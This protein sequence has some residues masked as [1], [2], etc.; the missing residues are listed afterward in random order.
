MAEAV[1]D[2]WVRTTVDGQSDGGRTLAAGQVIDVSA[3][4]SISLRAGDG[5][6]I[7]V[8]LNRGQKQPLGRSGQPVT[9]EFDLEKAETPEPAPAPQPAKPVPTA[10]TNTRSAPPIASAVSCASA[11]DSDADIDCL[12]KAAIKRLGKSAAG[13]E[14]ARARGRSTDSAA[15]EFG[16]NEQRTACGSARCRQSTECASE[17]VSACC[18]FP[19]K[20]RPCHR[21]SVAGRLPSSGPGGDGGFVHRELAAR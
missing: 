21:P 11:T 1:R 16:R 10:P 20:R 4:K 3:E 15:G 18:C 7:L 12:G 14:S 5:G 13:T 2:V 6:A 9:R 17:F 19:G 8:S